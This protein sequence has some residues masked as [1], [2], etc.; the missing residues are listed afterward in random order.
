[1]NRYDVASVAKFNP[2]SF[3]EL[4]V[5]P[6]M[7]RQK[8]D[9][10]IAQQELLRQ[11]LA[12]TNPHE[13]YYDE[14]VR[15]KN[16]LNDQITSQAESL[17]KEG[18]NPNSQADF[19]KLNRNY[20]ETMSP[21]GKLGMI[22]AHNV[23]LQSTYKNYID[24]AIKAGQS[25]AIAK[26]HAD[27]AIQ[28][29]MQQP[30]YDERGRVVDFS[31]GNSAPKYIDNIKWINDLATNVGFSKNDWANASSGISQDA[32]GRFIVN[33]NAKGMTKDNIENLNRLTQI[34]NSQVSDPSSEI[35]QNIDYNFKNPQTELD[36]M[37]NQLYARRINERDREQG[38]SIGSM[39]WK[40][41][42]ETNDSMNLEAVNVEGV[43]VTKNS[44]LLSKLNGT[45]VTEYKPIDIVASRA[46]VKQDLNNKKQSEKIQKETLDSQEYKNLARGIARTQNLGNDLKSQ[47]VQDAVKK[48]LTDNKD[49]TIQNRYVDPNTNKQGM[50][51]ASK[52]LTGKDSKE[53]AGNLILERV[54]RGAY[55]MVDEEGNIIDKNDVGNY[56]FVYSGDM[57][58]KSQ[59]GKKGKG[60]FTNPKQNIG[61]RTGVLVDKET[62]ESKTVY[63]SRGADDFNTPQFKAM[64]TISGISKIADIQPGIYHAIKSPLFDNY[65]MKNVEVKYNKNK[66]TYDM[67]YTNSQGQ[68]IDATDIP[69]SQFQENIL[70]DY[71]NLYKQ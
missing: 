8:H 38:Y 33:S 11:N 1:M 61:A 49:V 43:D 4:S 36:S 39:D 14:A 65:G 60:L 70:N 37:L 21:T 47:K 26:L 30:L 5:A 58:P 24:E 29:H 55:D 22:N 35:R 2:M 28:K 59:I 7:Q 54:R 3:Q 25:P 10:L 31:A 6:L 18:V 64:E 13:K 23:N 51:F 56:D 71:N 69:D 41:A 34:A 32:N 27:Q 46:G 17:A 67:S 45:F 42:D 66:N 44:N 48:Y 57:T 50:L 68:N 12:K 19:L 16:E 52:E 9:Q 62:G 63:V 15:L 53:K 20:Q 40:K